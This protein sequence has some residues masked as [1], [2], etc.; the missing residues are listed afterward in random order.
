MLLGNTFQPSGYG[1]PHMIHKLRSSG[2]ILCQVPKNCLLEIYL[3]IEDKTSYGSQAIKDRFITLKL[4][5]QDLNLPQI[6]VN[7]GS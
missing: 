6:L 3:Y 7:C 4:M 5:S 2:Y 1:L